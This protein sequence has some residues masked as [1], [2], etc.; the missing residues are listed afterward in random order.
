[1]AWRVRILKRVGDFFIITMKNLSQSEKTEQ[2]SNYGVVK[3]ERFIYLKTYEY[4]IS[5]YFIVKNKDRRESQCQR[6]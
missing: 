4:P 2:K 5:Y 3:I 6:T 1:M